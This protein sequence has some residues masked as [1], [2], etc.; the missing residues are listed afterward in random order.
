VPTENKARIYG[1]YIRQIAKLVAAVPS[2]RIKII[3]HSSRTGREAYNDTLSMQRSVWILKEMS[4]Y[5]P[6]IADRAETSGRGF[7][8]N[9]VGTGTDDITD[10]IDRRVEFKFSKCV[11]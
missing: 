4:S 8:E 9:I 3:G 7:R 1:I 5:V 2:C 11:E 6:E 10:E